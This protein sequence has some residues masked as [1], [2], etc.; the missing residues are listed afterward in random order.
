MAT[1]K[2]GR[3]T[4]KEALRE[5]PTLDAVELETSETP[6]ATEATE[7]AEATEAPEGLM[8]DPNPNNFENSLLK[9]SFLGNL[10]KEDCKELMGIL[11]NV[12]LS[13]SNIPRRTKIKK[14]HTVV[15]NLYNLL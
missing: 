3:P 4:K 12:Y 5:M 11:M 13:D 14:L 6:E 7:A 15:H 1:K 2:R 10:T 9:A 8:D